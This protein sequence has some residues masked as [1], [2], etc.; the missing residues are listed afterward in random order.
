M[1]SITGEGSEKYVEVEFC[2]INGAEWNRIRCVQSGKCVVLLCLL[3]Q[4]QILSLDMF[5]RCKHIKSNVSHLFF[6]RLCWQ[7][8][9]SSFTCSALPSLIPIRALH[10]DM[11]AAKLTAAGRGQCTSTL[12]SDA[13]TWADSNG[14]LIKGA[15]LLTKALNLSVIRL[16]WVEVE[17]RKETDGIT[18]RIRQVLEE[19]PCYKC[20]QSLVAVFTLLFMAEGR[21]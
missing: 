14:L 12:Y 20:W 6:Q 13:Y 11:Q 2:S 9:L 5:N 19:S 15:A 3:L 10:V 18:Y 17:R 1:L 8:Q 4:R 7:P 21:H 16:G